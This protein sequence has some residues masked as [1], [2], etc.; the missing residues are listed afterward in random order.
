MPKFLLV[1]LFVVSV[2]AQSVIAL[3]SASPALWSVR[4]SEGDGHLY[5]LGSIHFGSPELYPLP[6]YVNDAFSSS[7]ILAV[8]LDPEALEQ[9]EVSLALGHH[10]R[11]PQG[12]RLQD[13]LSDLQWQRVEQALSAVDLPSDAM[14]RLKPW[15]VAVQI[16]AAQVRRAGYSEGYGVDRYFL[17]LAHHPSAPKPIVEL[18]TFAAQMRIFDSLTLQQQIEFLLQTLKDLETAPEMLNNLITAWRVGDTDSLSATIK[19]SFSQESQRLHDSIFIQRNDK[20]L[21][22]LRALLAQGEKVFVVVGAGHLLGSYGL[23]HQL[24]QAGYI[25]NRR[26]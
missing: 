23:V 11:L 14:Q 13:F 5:L 18:E 25:V 12:M 3:E 6:D 15:L 1:L 22:K 2:V 19:Q 4:T 9:A 20:M 21:R 16:T 10:G 7:D 24:K 17:T 8:E 26:H